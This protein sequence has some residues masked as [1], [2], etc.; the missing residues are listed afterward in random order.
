MEKAKYKIVVSEPWNFDGPAGT[1]LIVGE[2]FKVFSPS[3]LI[4]KSDHLISFGDLKGDILI[5]VPRYEE[6]LFIENGYECIVGGALFLL[7]DFEHK[8]EKF[9]EDNSKYVLIGKLEKY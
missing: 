4:F 9:M 6:Q 5:L 2:I 1:N 7:T 3:K 8:T